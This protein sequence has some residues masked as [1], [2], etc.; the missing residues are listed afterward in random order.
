MIFKFSFSTAISLI[1]FMKSPTT[2]CQKKT[3]VL[4]F[5]IVAVR[6]LMYNV[7]FVFLNLLTYSNIM[8]S[9]RFFIHLFSIS[10]CPMW[11]SGAYVGQ[12]I[13]QD[14][15]LSHRRAHS[16]FTAMSNLTPVHLN[17]F[18]GLWGK[19]GD[20]RGSP[21]MAR[22]E[23][24]HY[25]YRVGTETQTHATVLTTVALLPPT[26]GLKNLFPKKTVARHPVD[27]IKTSVLRGKCCLA[28]NLLCD[29]LFFRAGI[30][31]HNQKGHWM[32]GFP[33][34]SIIRKDTQRY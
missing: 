34:N 17:M 26:K 5:V 22:G 9:P 18:I 2:F 28:V 13:T 21:T 15:V 33:Y 19:L 7:H 12:G 25:T 3:F 16:Q 32:C 24:A 11:G 6:W 30:A 4:L 20:P 1:G 23:H 8:H 14:R 10:A 29:C 27:T 31:N